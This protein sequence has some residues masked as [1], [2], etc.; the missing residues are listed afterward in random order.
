MIVM[1][2]RSSHCIPIRFKSRL[3]LGHFKTFF[4]FSLSHSEVDLRVCLGSLSCCIT[5]VRLRSQT[6][7]LIE[8]RINASI[9]KCKAAPDHHTTTS[10]FD[11]CYAVLFMK[12]CVG[13]TP[14]LKWHS[15]TKK[16]QKLNF[17]ISYLFLNFFIW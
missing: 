1:F 10:M 12:Y 13:F 3:C 9:K 15:P 7:F 8:R 2:L 4:L 11:C 16:F 6:D 17:F 5:Q 14:D